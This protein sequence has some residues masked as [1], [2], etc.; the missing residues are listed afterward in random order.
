MLPLLDVGLPQQGYVLAWRQ[1]ARLSTPPA[2]EAYVMFVDERHGDARI[3]WV[4]AT[5]LRPVVSERPR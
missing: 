1:T 2:W 5:C 3:E 4:P